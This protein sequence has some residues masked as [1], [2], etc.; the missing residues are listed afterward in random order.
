[1]TAERWLSKPGGGNTIIL[2]NS[3]GQRIAVKNF[4]M[5]PSKFIN[6]VVS[7]GRVM[8]NFCSVV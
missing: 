7:T 8:N 5:S 3:D 2:D 6:K 4:I 1:M